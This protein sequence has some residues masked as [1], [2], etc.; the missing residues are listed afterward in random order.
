MLWAYSVYVRCLLSEEGLLLVT[1]LEATSSSW[2]HLSVWPLDWGWYPDMRLTDAPRAL[3]SSLQTW[4]MNCGPRSEM[5]SVGMPWMRK[6]WRT[7]SWAVSNADGNLDTWTKWAA[8][9]NLSMI[10]KITVLPSDGGRPVMKSMEMWDQGWLGVG[11]G[12]RR[13]AGGW[14]LLLFRAQVGQAATNSLIWFRVGHQNCILVKQSFDSPQ[15]GRLAYCYAP[16]PGL[17]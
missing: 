9:E 2:L 11:S 3:Q 14:L 1:H 4:E 15:G 5:M 6:T 17:F 10:E 16:N 8:L 13:P 12:W 7:R